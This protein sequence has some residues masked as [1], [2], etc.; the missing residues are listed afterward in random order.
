MVRESLLSRRDTTGWR[1]T[2][3]FLLSLFLAVTFAG[4]AVAE[5]GVA[6]D[7]TDPEESFELDVGHFES[8]MV[9][10]RQEAISKG[11]APFTF[12][13][14]TRDLHPLPEVLAKDRRQ[15]EFTL[16]LDRYLSRAVTEERV[17]RARRLMARHAAMLE[18]VQARYGVQGRFLVSIWAL[19]SNFGDYTGGFPVVAAL[20][21]LAYDE[22]RADFF[23]EQLFHA[24]QILQD[25]HIG[26]ADMTGSWAGAMGQVQFMP[27]T[28]TN[29]AQDGNGDGRRDI[30]QSLPDVFAS[31]A[32]YLSEV[33]WQGD[34]TWGRE[35]RLP[36]GFDWTLAGMET[37]RHI[38]EWQRLGV[39]RADGND[40]PLADIEGSVILP[41]GHAGPA[42]LVYRNYRTTLIWNRSTLYAIAVGHLADRI[43]GLGPL[44]TKRDFVESRMHRRDIEMLQEHLN[45]LGYDVGAAD[46]LAGSRTRAALK[47]F[48]LDRGLPADG[49]PSQEVLDALTEA[50][51]ERAA[52][53]AVGG[54]ENAMGQ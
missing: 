36:D 2:V 38:G 37:R 34:E 31:A 14:A 18:R 13:E 48:Q 20:L 52:L 30:W 41:A 4:Y 5:S 46:G 15:P 28:F 45:T 32:N 3:C 54:S 1:K 49:H 9:D 33:G 23:R 44:M 17:R 26:M 50:V 24:L 29:Y 53:T 42:F 39:R 51:R 21:T 25:G 12:D 40:L 19:E 22:R 11:I 6:K 35:V 27:S 7:A 8:W 47:A 43:A 16:T 10:L